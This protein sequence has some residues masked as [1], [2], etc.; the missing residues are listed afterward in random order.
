[1]P[2]LSGKAASAPDII[3]QFHEKTTVMPFTMAVQQIRKTT[4]VLKV[5]NICYM[6]K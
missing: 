1:M 6:S 2:F 3:F 4:E 5:I